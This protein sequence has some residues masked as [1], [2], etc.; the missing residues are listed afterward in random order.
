M[1]MAPLHGLSV[2]GFRST[3]GSAVFFAMIPAAVA[4]D[5]VRIIARSFIPNSHP[6]APGTIVPVP[7]KPGAHMLKDPLPTG[8]CFDTDHRGFSL[9]PAAP[10]RLSTDITISLSKPPVAR[11]TSGAAHR[12]G[13]TVQRACSDGAEVK[14]ATAAVSACHIGTPAAAGSVT[15]VVIGC[16]AGNPLVPGA[17]KIDYGGTITYDAAAKT[18][19]FQATIGDFPAFE[20]LASLNGKP[21]KR[22]FAVGP[23]PGSSP[24]ALFDAGLGFSSRPLEKVPVKL[25]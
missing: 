2:P 21:F 23:A 25:D 6:T 18:I 14:R 10:S 1:R 8:R 7:G 20:A 19:A 24:L 22:I 17:P 15:Q 5:S 13:P 4:Q 16:S 9:D 11:S 3:L 12:A